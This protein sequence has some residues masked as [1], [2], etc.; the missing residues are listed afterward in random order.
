[1]LAAAPRAEDATPLS[2]PSWFGCFD[3]A[4]LTRDLAAGRAVAY[5]AGT[6]V[7]KDFERIIAVYPDGRAYMWRQLQKE[8]RD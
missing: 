7:P 2:A 3:H 8:F 1:S 6:D 4:Q 5:R